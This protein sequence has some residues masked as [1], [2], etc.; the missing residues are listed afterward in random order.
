[1]ASH[2]RFAISLPPLPPSAHVVLYPASPLVRRHHFSAFSSFLHRYYRR[3]RRCRRIRLLYTLS[4]SF[5]AFWPPR[6]VRYTTAFVR[7]FVRTFVYP[8]PRELVQ[9]A[10]QRLRDPC[11]ARLG[12]VHGEYTARALSFTNVVPFLP[13]ITPE[14][15]TEREQASVSFKS[16]LALPHPSPFSSS[17]PAGRKKGVPGCPGDSGEQEG[18]VRVAEPWDIKLVCSCRVIS[19]ATCTV[20]ARETRTSLHVYRS[21][22][23]PCCDGHAA[24]SAAPRGDDDVHTADGVDDDDDNDDVRPAWREERRRRRE[25]VYAVNSANPA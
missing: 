25:I 17:Q 7:S 18:L 21:L 9:S 11:R 15:F 1:M 6:S 22:K 4:Y 8:R 12:V 2:P 24:G 23:N 13:K 14:V 10:R 20:L 3:R 19:R 16:T 5:D